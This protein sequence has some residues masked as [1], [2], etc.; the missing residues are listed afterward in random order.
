MGGISWSR[1]GSG[2]S[3]G[4]WAARADSG[5]A[6]GCGCGTV[7]F[8]HVL[9]LSGS[10]TCSGGWVFEHSAPLLCSGPRA[11][12]LRS[13][14]P[15]AFLRWARDVL[16]HGR[17]NYVG[18]LLA[19]LGASDLELGA[20]WGRVFTFHTQEM[21]KAFGPSFTICCLECCRLCRQRQPRQ[22]RDTAAPTVICPISPAAVSA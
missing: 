9:F 6:D 19:P 3:C 7:L 21:M 2:V 11:Q 12:S 17:Q 14:L 15:R 13:L 22:K 10:C 20:K 5:A 18:H 1:E 16:P 4:L 8:G